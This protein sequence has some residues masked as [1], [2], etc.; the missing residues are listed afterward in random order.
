MPD[1]RTHP[2]AEMPSEDVLSRLIAEK[3]PQHHDLYLAAHRLVLEAAPDV[4]VSV[5]L[6]DA[7]IGYGAH[8][9]GYNGWG[10]GA[11]SPHAKWVSLILFRGGA[12]DDPAGL[13]EGTGALVRHVKL[14]SLGDFESRR[15][16]LTSLVKSAVGAAAS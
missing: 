6:H 13:L 16:A 5:D 12:L 7:V 10:M 3:H 11:V 15:E 2:H 14:T 9:Y 8:Q 4:R 1:S